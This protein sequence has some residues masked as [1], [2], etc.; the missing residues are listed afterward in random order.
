MKRVLENKIRYIS[1]CQVF[2][3]EAAL[4]ESQV[5]RRFLEKYLLLQQL[6]MLVAAGTI[7]AI[8]QSSEVARQ[9]KSDPECQPKA[10]RSRKQKAFY[11]HKSVSIFEAL[12]GSTLIPKWSNLLSHQQTQRRSHRTAHGYDCH[13]S[14]CF[15]LILGSCFSLCDLLP[16]MYPHVVLHY[17]KEIN[18]F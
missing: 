13:G 4:R 5:L 7:K 1:W 11:F 10:D 18:I 14:Y 12:A 6:Q 16:N 8:N 3:K 2:T 9:L 15:F 17:Q